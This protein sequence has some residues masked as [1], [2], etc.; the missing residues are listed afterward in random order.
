MIPALH[1]NTL[2]VKYWHTARESAGYPEEPGGEV[3]EGH[4]NEYSL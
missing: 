4:A 3:R 1:R 2:R